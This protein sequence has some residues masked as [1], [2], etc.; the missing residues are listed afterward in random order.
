MQRDFKQKSSACVT[1]TISSLSEPNEYTPKFWRKR[2]QDM[3]VEDSPNKS[4]IIISKI[5]AE[6]ESSPMNASKR[7]QEGQKTADMTPSNT[8][9]VGL[10]RAEQIHSKEVEIIRR[11]RT[12]KD[13]RSGRTRKSSNSSTREKKGASAR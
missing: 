6:N 8:K 3:S 10:T 5:P 9:A 13:N 4:Q 12:I 11:R 2:A 1:E 7:K